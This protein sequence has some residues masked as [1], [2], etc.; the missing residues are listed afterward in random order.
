[1]PVC[2]AGGM[3]DAARRAVGMHRTPHAVSCVRRSPRAGAVAECVRC[4]RHFSCNNRAE[5]FLP[6]VNETTS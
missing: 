1:V 5:I 6:S 3:I 2:G 4:V